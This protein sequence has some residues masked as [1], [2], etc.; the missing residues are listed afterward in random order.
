MSI[1]EKCVSQ[2]WFF[3]V[4]LS[5]EA[6]R[7]IFENQVQILLQNEP[8]KTKSSPPIFGIFTQQIL[9]INKI[10]MTIIINIFGLWRTTNGDV[11]KSFSLVKT[12][13]RGRAIQGLSFFIMRE[14]G[15]KYGL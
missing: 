2:L 11:Q 12:Y 9:D 10:F 1:E 13:S 3:C 15:Y 14:R 6:Q 7:K 8:K 4:F 5:I